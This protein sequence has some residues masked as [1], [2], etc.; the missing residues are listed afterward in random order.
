MYTVVS[1]LKNIYKIQVRKMSILALNYVYWE[2]VNNRTD[3]TGAEEISVRL[4]WVQT[5]AVTTAFFKMTVFV[6]KSWVS[7]LFCKPHW[8]IISHND[9]SVMD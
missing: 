2:S 3:S 9:N 1:P 8:Q 4:L 6:H 5:N 7:M